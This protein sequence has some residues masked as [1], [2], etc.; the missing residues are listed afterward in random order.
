[1]VQTI[2]LQTKEKIIVNNDWIKFQPKYGEIYKVNLGNGNDSVQGGLRPCLVMQN[3]IGNKYSPN[4]VVLPMT[5]QFTKAKL[6][7]HVEVSKNEGIEKDSLILTE[8]PMTVSK[9]AF[10]ING[11]PKKVT[12]LSKDK[13]IE[14]KDALKVEFGMVDNPNFDQQKAFS[15]IE[16]IHALNYNI[17]S[18]QARG[19][20]SIFNEK[21]N[22][23][24]SYCLLHKKDSNSILSEYSR[25][26]KCYVM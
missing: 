2:N 13:M 4:V 6:P 7:T 8:Q 10:Y 21:V 3:D 19:L 26:K 22:E 18:K 1:M 20:R 25:N 17:K 9:R 11:Y 5:S 12:T 15:L 23:L 16:Q 24:Q 14:V